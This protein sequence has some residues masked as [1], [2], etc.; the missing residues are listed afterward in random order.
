MKETKNLINSNEG[1]ELFKSVKAS[2]KEQ[3]RQSKNTLNLTPI[4]N[5]LSDAA[6]NCLSTDCVN[7]Y[8]LQNT[9]KRTNSGWYIPGEKNLVSLEKK[10][11]KVMSKMFNAR[12]ITTR[13]LSGINAM[14]V[15]LTALFTP[16]KRILSINK[17]LGG[18]SAT[19]KI[20]KY[21][22][23]KH[24]YLPFN[25]KKVPSIDYSKLKKMYKEKPVDVIYLDLSCILF[26]INIGKLR[27]AT[28]GNTVI[29]YDGSH[30]LGLIANDLF[31]SPLREG[32]D[33]L[34]GSLHKTFFGPQRGV[35]ATNKERHWKKIKPIIET[36]ISNRHYNDLAALG[37]SIAEMKDFGKKYAK[38][39]IKNG[40]G[41]ANELARL[42]FNVAGSD[43]GYTKSHQVWVKTER[44][45]SKDF[46][47]S[48]FK[49]GIILNSYLL[50]GSKK[51]G[52]RIG[53]QGI[54]R[55]GMKEEEMQKIAQALKDIM[56][57]EISTA[58]RIVNE[59]TKKFNMVSFSYGGLNA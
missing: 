3:E 20:A 21:L 59:L 58:K 55:L 57:N 7:R 44:I 52:L 34:C 1:Y 15:V 12:H 6:L 50:P 43:K 27:N 18:H 11:D 40:R 10:I 41:L 23:Y 48:A 29:C 51:P 38:Q 16:G 24:E 8:S 35:I 25:E 33:I 36:K 9:K 39:S 28:S 32:A 14:E 5:F 53:V 49:A 17:S 31:Q 4:E 46:V 19:S 56:E 2:V 37:I 45:N 47:I 42:G 26:P 30:V 54:T 13:P 22:G